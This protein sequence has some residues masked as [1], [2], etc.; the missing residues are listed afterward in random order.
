MDNLLSLTTE[1]QAA[2]I[3]CSYRMGVAPAMALEMAVNRFYVAIMDL[4]EGDLADV[5]FSGS[6]SDKDAAMGRDAVSTSLPGCEN[7]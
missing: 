3:Q 1:N 6:L 5:D 7:A 4:K 2:L